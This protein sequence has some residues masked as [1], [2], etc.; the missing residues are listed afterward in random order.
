MF[1][2]LITECFHHKCIHHGM[3]TRVSGCS[4]NFGCVATG[5]D[6]TKLCERSGRP[7]LQLANTNGSNGPATDYLLQYIQYIGSR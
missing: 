4:S 3:A 5:S 6:F 2:D 7:V 1:S